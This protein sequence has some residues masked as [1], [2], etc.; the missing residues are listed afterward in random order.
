METSCGNTL[1]RWRRYMWTTPP[2]RD[3]VGLNFEPQFVA[4][5]RNISLQK[6]NTESGTSVSSVASPRG[7]LVNLKVFPNVARLDRCCYNTNNGCRSGEQTVSDRRFRRHGLHRTVHRGGGCPVCRREPRQ[8]TSE[9][10]RGRKKQSASGRSVET[11][12]GEAV[13]VDGATPHHEKS[14][15]PSRRLVNGRKTN[16]TLLSF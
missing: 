5:F 7:Q 15:C 14:S 16:K 13:Y 6:L 1:P 8:C 9:V 10:G 12:R 2:W 3:T 4:D 11:S